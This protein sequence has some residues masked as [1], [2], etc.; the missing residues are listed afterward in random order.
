[1]HSCG[2]NMNKRCQFR[3][4]DGRFH[5]GQVNVLIAHTDIGPGDGATMVVPAS[6]KAN[7]HHPDLV[8]SDWTKP[9]AQDGVEGA[10]EVHL[11]AGDAAIFVDQIMHGAA[12]RVNPGQRRI[13]VYRYGPSW[14]TFRHG[15]RVSPELLERLT[16]A[17]RKIVQPMD[18]VLPPVAATV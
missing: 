12:P 13:S 10:I 2:A 18:P 7:F 14:G 15:Y 6:H 17:R 3:Y 1:M 16:P 5:N 4:H 11:K 8:G 9:K